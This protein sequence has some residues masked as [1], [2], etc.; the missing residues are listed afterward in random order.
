[1]PMS[2]TAAPSASSGRLRRRSALV[3]ALFAALATHETRAAIVVKPETQQRLG[4]R[5]AVLPEQR[6]SVQVDAFAKVLDPGPLAALESDLDSAV[7]ASAASTAE[8]ARA[9]ELAR[10]GE[11]LARKDAE[12]AVAQAKADQAKLALL[13]RR[14]GLE[15]GPGVARMPDR[16]RIQLIQ[17][18]SAGKA[19]LVQ[20]DTPSNEGQAGARSVEID[21]GDATVHAPVL[22]PSRNAEAR[23]QSSGLI[24]LVTGPKAILFSIGLTQSARINTSSAVSGVVVPRSAI[25]RFRGSA[26]TYVA[27]GAGF[28]R[29]LLESPEPESGGLFVA[30]GVR[31]GEAVAVQGAAG[32]FAAEQG[33]SRPDD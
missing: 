8:A 26:W 2:R 11:N 10:S 29:R 3:L 28:E 24:A 4:V 25:V 15:W 14:I 17:D 12:A 6:R 20:V 31:P 7:A 18:L 33:R 27:E 13:R 32:L 5:T 16:R 1:M 9:T 22:G 21:I 23:L 19:A 30:R